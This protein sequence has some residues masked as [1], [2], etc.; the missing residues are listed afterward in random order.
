LFAALQKYRENQRAYFS[1]FLVTDVNMQNS[2]MLI[3]AP[4]EF[5]EVIHYP[6]LAPNLFELN[7]VVSRKKQLVPYLLDCLQR[8]NPSL[9]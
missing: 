7:N 1:A 5:L 9:S 6:V 4:P 2:R 3:A 8:V